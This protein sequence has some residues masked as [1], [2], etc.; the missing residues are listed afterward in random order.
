MK[1]LIFGF[2][3]LDCLPEDM[4]IL[5]DGFHI[6]NLAAA[7]QGMDGC[8]RKITWQMVEDMHFY[9]DAVVDIRNGS[10]KQLTSE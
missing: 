6:R 3:F 7:S 4:I 1:S 10:L 5:R 2:L 9:F 8:Y